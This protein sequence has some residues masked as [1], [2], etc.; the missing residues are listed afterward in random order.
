MSAPSICAYCRQPGMMT[1]EHL[2]PACLH[3]RNFEANDQTEKLFFLARFNKDVSREPRIRDVCATCNNVVLSK[4]DD[5]ICQLFD[6]TLIRSHNRHEVVQFDFDYHLLKRWLL[7]MCFNSAR[8]NKN[9]RDLDVLESVLPY[10]MGANQLL[11]RSIQLF[12]H[13]TYPEQVP[14]EDLRP[15]Y[16][17]EQPVIVVPNINRVGHI[18]FAVPGIG[19]RILRAVHLRAYSF[20]LAFYRRNEQRSVQDSFSK[21]FTMHMDAT[22]LLRPSRQH[23]SLECNGMGAWTSQRGARETRFI[24]DGSMP[25]APT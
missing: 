6:R 13:L 20:F 16:A 7:K 12:V 8:I 11:G 18:Q 23:I 9:T 25:S 22:V 14:A 1:Q 3:R 24:S 17:G 15:A 5:Y 10:I 19:K 2:W 4:L 21:D